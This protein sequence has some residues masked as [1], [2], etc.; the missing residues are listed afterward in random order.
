MQAIEKIVLHTNW[1]PLVWVA[2]IAAIAVLKILD[3]NRLKGYAFSLFNK[4]FIEDEIA[5]NTTF[6]NV[7]QSLI[8]I[9]S[10]VVYAL[11]FSY[12]LHEFT[13]YF[14]LSFYSFLQVFVL[15]MVYFLVKK[16]IESAVSSLFL[17]R[18]Q[19][20][21]YIVS[22]YAYQYAIAFL[23][24]VL[25]TIV[26][27]SPLKPIV[28]AYTILFLFFAKFIFLVVNNKKLIF[29]KLF[30]FI[31]YICALE[32]APLFILFKLLL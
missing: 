16:T 23:L 29:S 30:Y 3:A 28:F 27:F 1:V 9:F 7:F 4:T 10:I 18:K 13:T 15:T 24:F 21:F 5:E 12:V 25:F 32:I 8:F 14:S 26:K 19:V 22:K 31:L 17:I 20:R 2:L 11:S 6:L